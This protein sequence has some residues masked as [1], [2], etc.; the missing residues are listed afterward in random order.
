MLS[1]K[2]LFALTLS[3][4]ALAACAGRQ[5]GPVTATTPPPPT[6]AFEAS[7]VPV[8]EGYRFGKLDNGMRYIVRSN[9]TPKGQAL[10]RMVV[11]T[12]ALD[13]SDEE[14]GFAHFVEHM[15]FNGS[16]NVPEGEMVKLLERLG[17]AFG[18]DTN[19]STGF[20]RT[21]Y[22]L[23]L[24][25]NDPA[26]L[27]TALML[28][29]ETASELTISEA[30][31]ERE[32]GVILSEKR[33]RNT[34]AL[35]N[36]VDQI[37]FQHPGARYTRRLPIGTEETLKAATAESLRAFWRREYVP[38]QTTVIVVGDFPVEAMEAAIRARF[39][40]W[41]PAPAEPQPKAGPMEVKGPP[42]EDIFIDQ[43]LSERISV[44]RN[45]VWLDEPDSLA[46]R[47]ENLLRQ[48]GYGIVNRRL[49]RRTREADPPFRGA[50]LGTADQFREGRTTNL[51]VDT[52]DGGWQRGLAAATEEYRRALEY[53]FTAEEVA[54]QVANSR[55]A[56]RNAAAS[57]STRSHGTL[58]G[59]VLALVTDDVVPDKPTRS[60]ERL[61]AFI[62]QI[63]PEAVM[64]ALKRELVPLD[65]PLIRFQGRREPDGGAKALRA[66]WDAAVKATV[67]PPQA[68]AA[69]AFAYTDFGPPGQV[70]ADSTEP[71]FGIRQVRFANG[72]M[73][74]LKRT[75][76]TKDRV[77]VR[78]SVDGGNMLATRDNP[79]AVQMMGVFGQGGLGKHSK[80]ELDS[81]LAGRTVAT[82]LG[83][84]A[85]TFA[86][87][88]TTTPA[89]LELQLQ[90]FAAQ[91]ADPGYRPEGEVLFRQTINNFFAAIGA[92]PDSALGAELG[93]ILS[94]QDPRFALGKVEDY[95]KLGFAALREA[96]ADRL[97]KG[98]IELALV[99]DF[100]EAK[101]IALV[102]R[103]LGALPPREAAFRPYAEQ[104]NRSFTADRTPRLPRHKGAKDQALLTL[105]WPTRDGEDLREAIALE[106]LQRV[107][108]VELTDTL[109]EALGK[110]Y[111]PGVGASTPRVWR[112]W[113]TFT[114]RAS[115]DVKE[116]AA[117]RAAI[118]GLLEELRKAPVS[119]DIVQRARAPMLE[120][121][122]AV[123]KT[124]A[125][126]M[127]LADRAQS[128]PDG[129][130]RYAASRAIITALT[131][132]D[133][134]ALARRYL[135]PDKGLEVL[136]L[137]EG[138]EP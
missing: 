123:L 112:G 23:D 98:A 46:Q 95:R 8:D 134:L 41:R 94:D 110:T 92:T 74:N 47:R 66:A 25:R 57:E 120:N 99:G 103:T 109:R 135:D 59:A 43:A 133:L 5:P 35:R 85:E 83:S 75:D 13:E 72:V 96:I 45:D 90:V 111:S 129:I 63:T 12:G 50:G 102:G 101:A 62:P 86:A 16:T 93:G 55:T 106:L 132:E 33:D 124:N 20:D 117:T 37:E 128:K 31:V 2:S 22:M 67:A 18:A 26:L 42:R 10:V 30:A 70:V 60:L 118:R 116:V 71:R 56:A 21:T 125:G 6:W 97:A 52:V 7:D 38:A 126:W 14:R 119:A 89:D 58:L 64:A 48:I 61:E 27:D 87:G 4:L 54:E 3:T 88:A 113:G 44:T 73:L 28:M 76:L 39:A 65:Q 82:G 136:V 40:D 138:V 11:K 127:G 130:D 108:Q 1:R 51:I 91:L 121:L 80:D 84:G 9:A 78:L 131:A 19:A 104:R 79:L 15:A 29:R 115:V 107:A 81:L 105:H 77:Q 32:R 68:K 17:L 114:V 49:L 24:P 122:D 34:F 137:P 69:G 100:D 36:V 53:G